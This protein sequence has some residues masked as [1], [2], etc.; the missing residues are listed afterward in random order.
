MLDPATGSKLADVP[1][2]NADDARRA[3]DAAHQAFPAWAAKP[4]KDRV[5][6]FCAAG[7]NCILA[8]TE[9]LAQLMTAEQGKPLC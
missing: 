8:E 7:T 4:A 1:D 9:S 6:R 5:C 3:I 2:L